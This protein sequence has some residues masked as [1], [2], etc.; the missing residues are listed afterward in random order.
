MWRLQKSQF[1]QGWAW[2]GCRELRFQQRATRKKQWL[3]CH[4]VTSRATGGANLA[5]WLQR[6]LRA[7]CKCP[8]PG[9]NSRLWRRSRR[10][11]SGHRRPAD[12]GAESRPSMRDVRSAFFRLLDQWVWF[13]SAA[14]GR[15]FAP[16]ATTQQ[17]PKA[18]R[19]NLSP[20][21]LSEARRG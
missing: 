7:L 21:K 3:Q 4:V 17:R 20:T 1:Q 11:R 8:G 6:A 9:A 15:S 19:S 16:S 18:M 10:R 2:L 14:A 12:A 13:A 5:T